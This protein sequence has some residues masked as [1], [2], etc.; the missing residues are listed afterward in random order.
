MEQKSKT[1]AK[2]FVPITQD[3][4]GNTR[5]LHLEAMRCV[6]KLAGK[7]MRRALDEIRVAEMILDGWNGYPESQITPI[8]ARAIAS[9][10]RGYAKA[11]KFL[12]SHGFEIDR[13]K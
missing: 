13:G 8:G 5:R 12:K 7:E 9:A 10:R 11:V 3:E 4:V 1:K 6:E 2:K